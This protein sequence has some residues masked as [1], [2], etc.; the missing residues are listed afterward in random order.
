MQI[1]NYQILSVSFT[2]DSNVIDVSQLDGTSLRYSDVGK[3]DDRFSNL[4]AEKV[5]F[6]SI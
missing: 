4:I 3:G 5:M 1:L 2:K 6:K